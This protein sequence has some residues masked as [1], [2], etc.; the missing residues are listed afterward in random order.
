VDS[1]RYIG[2]ADGGVL[3]V[4]EQAFPGRVGRCTL[5]CTSGLDVVAPAESL[6]WFVA[7]ADDGFYWTTL[8]PN[9]GNIRANDGDAST[10][11]DL[12]SGRFVVQ[13][14]VHGPEVLFAERGNGVKAV[15]RD[16]GTVRRL[17][18][19]GA[20]TSRFAIDGNDVY[21]SDEVVAGRILRCNV[22]G[23][24]DAGASFATAQDYPHAIA[25]DKT[26]VYWTNHAT[27]SGAGAIVRLVK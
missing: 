8:V 26:S 17:L 6:P 25:V 10:P 22:N 3:L 23:C 7:S 5:P 24:G 2:A 4:S 13:I 11:V 16:G 14:E 21:F 15:L 9:G 27:V 12:V 20:D 19:Q 18:D 1:P